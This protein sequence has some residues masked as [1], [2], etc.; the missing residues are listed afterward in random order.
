MGHV[1]MSYGE[2]IPLRGRGLR[3]RASLQEILDM[4]SPCLS[5]L[6]VIYRANTKC[7]V[8]LIAGDRWTRIPVFQGTV[9]LRN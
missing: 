1:M 3:S 2:V 6:E 7:K 8:H 4:P 5:G 9:A